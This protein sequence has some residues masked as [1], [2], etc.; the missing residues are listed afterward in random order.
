MTRFLFVLLFVNILHI[1]AFAQ[2]CCD[3][4][5]CREEA[6]Y[7][8]TDFISILDVLGAY[9]VN[10]TQN[11][12]EE[13]F[14]HLKEQYPA[15]YAAIKSTKSD[16]E[17]WAEDDPTKKLC[18]V[19]YFGLDEN[20]WYAYV[21]QQETEINHRSAEFCKGPGLHFDLNFGARNP[22]GAFEGFANSYHLLGAYT[23]GKHRCGGFFRLMA[24]PAF[25]HMGGVGYLMGVL[26][27]ELRI[28]DI[29]TMVGEVGNLK[30]I[31]Q[32]NANETLIGFGGGPAV[33]VGRKV[34]V[35]LLGQYYI[36]EA[37]DF[38]TVQI[39]LGY[40]FFN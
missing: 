11:E 7:F 8:A 24:G 17:E 26:R 23:F 33:E 18:V 5:Q 34:S 1:P 14:N 30:L 35:Q 10:G 2:R 19:D 40:R 6:M 13:K 28:T 21:I 12:I 31:L 3:D 20:R 38:Y 15:K 32:G 27:T 16:Y 9:P 36:A 22:Y 39:G 29:A 25:Y 4:E 37:K